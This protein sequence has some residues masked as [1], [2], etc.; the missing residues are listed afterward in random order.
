MKRTY[1]ANMDVGSGHTSYLNPI[2]SGSK[3]DAIRT[4]KS[5]ARGEMTSCL[6]NAQVTVRDEKDHIVYAAFWIRD[7]WTE[8]DDEW[9]RQ[10]NEWVDY[11][12]QQQKAENERK[13]TSADR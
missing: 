2:V 11:K 8:Y 9:I 1:Y 4:I 5:L 7:C 6:D 10:E 3:R 12:K 13:G